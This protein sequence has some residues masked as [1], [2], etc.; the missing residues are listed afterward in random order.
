M[1][2]KRKSEMYLPCILIL[3]ASLSVASQIQKDRD[4]E[5]VAYHDASHATQYRN[6]PV[7]RQ[8]LAYRMAPRPCPQNKKIC[9]PGY[10]NLKGYCTKEENK[11][12]KVDVSPRQVPYY[13]SE[14]YYQQQYYMGR[15]SRRCGPKGSVRCYR[16]E[17]LNRRLTLYRQKKMYRTEYRTCPPN[18]VT[19]CNGFE[20]VHGNCIAKNVVMTNK[21]LIE[22]V[23]RS[24]G[25]LGKN[26]NM[27][28]IPKPARPVQMF[29]YNKGEYFAERANLKKSRRCGP[30]GSVRCYKMEQGYVSKFRNIQMIGYRLGP[31][32]ICPEKNIICCN[33]YIHI[34]GYCLHQSFA[35]NNLELLEKLRKD[36][37]I[38]G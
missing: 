13:V 21:E 18:Q 5:G 9:C 10:Y 8:K 24:G 38:V 6:A 33:E 12:C 17:Q 11:C 2:N 20:A 22:Q 37:G 27:C 1:W 16:S 7:Y 26:K 36:A 19:C 31:V 23:R 4:G 32:P 29:Y 30:K 15:V 3:I 28:C 35:V 34:K 14:S 25:D